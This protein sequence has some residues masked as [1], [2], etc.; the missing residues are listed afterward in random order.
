MTTRT[1]EHLKH[2]NEEDKAMKNRTYV[3]EFEFV[4]TR[5]G[6]KPLSMKRGF[7]TYEDAYV[8]ANENTDDGYIVEEEEI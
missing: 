6:M 1:Q 3:V 7:K 8:W 4:N 2:L 5:F